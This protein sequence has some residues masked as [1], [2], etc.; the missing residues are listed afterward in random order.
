[1]TVIIAFKTIFQ[2]PSKRADLVAR[3]M[4]GYSRHFKTII[5]VV[6]QKLRSV[7]GYD[8]IEVEKN[9][10]ILVN[11]LQNFDPLKER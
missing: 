6:E 4:K 5:E 8:L 3:V 7:F 2:L 1:M 9:T 10:Y 11:K